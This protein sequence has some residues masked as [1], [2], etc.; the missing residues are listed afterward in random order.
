MNVISSNQVLSHLQLQALKIKMA[1]KKKNYNFVA[2]AEDVSYDVII[3]KKLRFAFGV[4]II[5]NKMFKLLIKITYLL[6]KKFKD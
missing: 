5:E 4:V 1:K 3:K 6:H 2:I